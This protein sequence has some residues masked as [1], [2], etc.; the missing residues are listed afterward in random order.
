MKL[1]PTGG[2][3]LPFFAPLASAAT[4][5][6]PSTAWT[7]MIGNYDYL[8]DQQTGAASGDIVGVGTDYGIW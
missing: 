8:A 7:P 6:A 3:L 2:A 1:I 4:V 5:S